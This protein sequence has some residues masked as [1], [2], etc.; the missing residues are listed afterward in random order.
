[1]TRRRGASRV[2]A[3]IDPGTA[4]AAPVA[5]P[6]DRAH[7]RRQAV[8]GDPGARRRVVRHA[9]RR[10][11]RARRR[12]R[13]RQ[14]HA[15]QD[16]GRRPPAGQRDHPARRRGDHDPRAG[17]R[18][19]ARDRRGAPGAA[20]LSRPDGRGERLHRPRASTR[21]RTIDWAATRRGA[22]GAVQGARCPLRR[23]G[24]GPWPVDGRPAAHRDR[25]GAV[26]RC[27]RPG[28]RRADRLAVGP[29]GRPPVRDRPSPAR[30]RRLDPV[31]QPPAR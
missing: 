8:R 30:P 25:Q 7:R 13:R 12:E 6:R 26:V 15:G 18:P 5:V 23:H 11:P 2:T 9:T 14:E 29:R 22:A 31:R 16:P 24:A 19:L 4:P 21:F 3:A 20:P 27:A 17:P 10:G 1:M 28:P